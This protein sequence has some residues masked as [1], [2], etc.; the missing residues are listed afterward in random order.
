MVPAEKPRRRALGW[1]AALVLLALGAALACRGSDDESN[2]AARAA[3]G[4]PQVP[5]VVEQVMRRD[6]P[7]V[8]RGIGTVQSLHSVVLRTQVDGVVTEVLFKEGQTVRRGELLARIDD[9]AIAAS[10]AQ[11]RAQKARDEAQLASA[12]AD[13]VRYG[14][15]VAERAIARQTFD[16]QGALVAQL[17]AAVRADEATI[18]AAEVQRSFTR[19][20]APVS[21]RV[22]LRRVDPGNVVRMSDAQGLVTVAQIDPIAVVFPVAQDQLGRLQPLLA[23][24]SP[25]TA[26]VAFD[27]DAGTE[28]ARGKL[29][30]V[31]NQVDSSSGT[32]SLKA[33]MPNGDGKLWPGQ[34]VTVELETG[35]TRDA[36]VVSA[37]AVQRGEAGPYLFRVESG[38]AR[39]VPVAVGYQDDAIA[40][41]E[42]GVAAGDTVVV[43]GHS[44]LKNGSRV[45]P[46]EAKAAPAGASP[47][48]AEA[49]FAPQDP[50]TGP[51]GATAPGA[52]KP[53][54]GAANAP[55]AT[56]PAGA[57]NAPAG[58]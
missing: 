36:T 15:L 22:G 26:V 14:N 49:A 34:F 3:G 30:T 33:E 43:D 53:P 58:G 10:L 6:V 24:A 11:A 40:V 48:P 7:H 54:A 9:R 47:R 57:A 42:K 21:G 50:A 32:I 12:R 41:I 23:A 28:L 8:L 16:Q 19:I 31:D 27:R 25:D 46:S 2:G 13:L 29:I 35:L 52:A 18:A 17:E 56:A 38:A 5:V 45:S 4:G 20:V 55:G 44:R 1:L 51:A 39:V 37:R